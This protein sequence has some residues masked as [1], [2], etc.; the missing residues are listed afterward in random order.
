MTSRGAVQFDMLKF[1]RGW[2]GWD[3]R[4]M[5]SGREWKMD[6][7]GRTGEEAGS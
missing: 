2:V 7:I 6:E 1:C 3:G 4:M 5:M